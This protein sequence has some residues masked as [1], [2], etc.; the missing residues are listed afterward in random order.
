[1]GEVVHVMSLWQWFVSVHAH[2]FTHTQWAMHAGVFVCLPLT[3]AETVYFVPLRLSM[4]HITPCLSSPYVQFVEVK[5]PN[6]RLSSKQLL[7]LSRLVQ[8]GCEAEVCRVKGEWGV[9]LRC[10]E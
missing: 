10:A 7:W 4:D 6:D 8:W 5:G 2:P 9:R 1:M 3:Y